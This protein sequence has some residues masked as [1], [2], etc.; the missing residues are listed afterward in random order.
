MD[1]TILIVDDNAN[2]RIIAETLLRARGLRAVVAEDARSACDFLCYEGAAVVVLNLESQETDGIALL[3][4]LRGRFETRTLPIQPRVMVII[5]P[6]DSDLERICTDVGAD[7]LLRR[8]WALGHFLTTVEGLLN[9]ASGN[10]QE[11]GNRPFETTP[12]EE[13]SCP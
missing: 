8:P 7:A 10:V 3:R 13:A 5:G 12:P 6:T 11:E 2:T 1:E 9:A 4:R